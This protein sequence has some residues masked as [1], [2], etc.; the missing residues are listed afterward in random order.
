MKAILWREMKVTFGNIFGLLAQFAA[1]IFILLMFATTLSG[2][3]GLMTFGAARVNYLEY[4]APGIFGY[5]TFLLLGITSGFIRM[6]KQA[7]ILTIIALSKVSLD[8]YFWGKLIF[9]VFLTA[10]KILLIGG[11]AMLL[12]GHIAPLTLSKFPIFLLTLIFSVTI[13]YSLGLAIG[14]MVARA[15]IREIMMMLLMMPLTFASSMYYDI[16]LAPKPIQWIAAINPLT[17]SCNLFRG[18]YLNTMPSD[19]NLQLIILASTALV[20]SILAIYSLRRI[21]FE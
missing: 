14:A 19:A 7:G 20:L 9:Q 21:R 3:I 4:F 6:D 12:A 1:P 13:W 15:D 10:A 8:G 5:V 18:F 11:L 17:Y 16:S 2:N